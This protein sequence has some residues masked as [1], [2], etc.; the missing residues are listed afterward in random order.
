MMMALTCNC[1]E[2]MLSECNDS[3]WS[4]FLLVF[5]MVTVSWSFDVGANVVS[6]TLADVVASRWFSTVTETNEDTTAWQSCRRVVHSSLGSLCKLAAMN[7]FSRPLHLV[8]GGLSHASWMANILMLC[9]RFTVSYVLMQPVFFVSVYHL[10]FA[11]AVRRAR[12][13]F[14]THG[15]TV[16]I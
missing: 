11:E 2:S 12:A 10:N 7:C 6:A 3:D 1:S 16:S 14:R 4:I 5:W 15:R 9:L 13:I 8:V